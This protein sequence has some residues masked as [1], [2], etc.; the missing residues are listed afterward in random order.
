MIDFPSREEFPG[1][2]IDR[3]PEDYLLTPEDVAWLA[4]CAAFVKGALTPASALQAVWDTVAQHG[5][6]LH[7]D[8]FELLIDAGICDSSLKLLAGK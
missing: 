4:V 8:P 5:D 1:Y 2:V 3:L 7:I 6:A